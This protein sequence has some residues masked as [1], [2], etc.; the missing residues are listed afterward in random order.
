MD[1][2]PLVSCIMLV[3]QVLT[4]DILRCVD[5]FR[6]QTYPHKELIIV[7]NAKDQHLGYMS[8]EILD[9]P[10][11]DDII[12]INTP[13]ELSAG[14]A[15]NVGVESAS[16][17]IMAQFDTNYWYSPNRL[18]AQI[19]TMANEKAHICVLARTLQYSYISGRASI[20]Q[21]RQNAI[22]GTMIWIGD[23]QIEY[24][25]LSHGEEYGILRRMLQQ[26]MQPIAIDKPEL[27]CKLVLTSQERQF[28]P[29]N[30]D[31]TAEQF[32]I[33]TSISG[34]RTPDLSL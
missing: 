25:N 26:G 30:I 15:R 34:I 24:P 18:S 29:N 4:P 22:L 23:G 21:N 9:L 6:T 10:A 13:Y 17:Q 7:N 33:I 20:F 2:Y 11:S 5:C 31:L 1:E 12:I 27:C 32:A 3:G 28:V 8:P 16:G 19:A 14:A